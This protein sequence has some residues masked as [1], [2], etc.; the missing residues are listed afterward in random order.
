MQIPV[1]KYKSNPTKFVPS[2]LILKI[3]NH[4]LNVLLWK[5]KQ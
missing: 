5:R 1:K 4:N 2:F 3:D